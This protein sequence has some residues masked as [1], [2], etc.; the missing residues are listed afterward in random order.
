MKIISRVRDPSPY[1]DLLEA[2]AIATTLGL[3][4][5]VL[6][7]VA[8]EGTKGGGR[9]GL[10]NWVG[11]LVAVGAGLRVGSRSAR[12]GSSDTIKGAGELGVERVD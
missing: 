5:P 11:L 2:L 6:G 4:G 7:R 10:E 12:V 1:E 8:G 9:P 3:K